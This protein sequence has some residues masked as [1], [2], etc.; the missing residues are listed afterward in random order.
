MQHVLQSM[1]LVSDKNCS[2]KSKIGSRIKDLEPYVVHE[3][4]YFFTDRIGYGSRFHGHGRTRVKK[5]LVPQESSDKDNTN[6]GLTM[7]N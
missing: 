4:P 2:Y 7:R 3:S 5:N 1:F 6:P